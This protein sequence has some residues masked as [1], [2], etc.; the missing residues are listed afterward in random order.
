MDDYLMFLII[1]IG[2]PCVCYTI[3]QIVDR[4]CECKERRRQN[5]RKEK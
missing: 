1:V 5:E 4:I 2:L 3:Y